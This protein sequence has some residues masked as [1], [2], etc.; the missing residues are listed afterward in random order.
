MI[1]ESAIK[2][3]EIDKERLIYITVHYLL[4]QNYWT[5]DREKK[6]KVVIQNYFIFEHLYKPLYN[7]YKNFNEILKNIF[8]LENKP[9][10]FHFFKH[11]FI[12]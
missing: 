1:K 9:Y 12:Q 6:S 11:V 4:S 5:S 2:S 8:S 7:S 10:I 3:G